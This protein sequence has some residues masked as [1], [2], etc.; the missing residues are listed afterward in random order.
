MGQF[1]V[2][3]WSVYWAADHVEVISKLND[4]VLRVTLF[5]TLSVLSTEQ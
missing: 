3:F 4:D 1:G 5:M 2:N